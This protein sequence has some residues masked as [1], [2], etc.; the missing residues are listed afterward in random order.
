MCTLVSDST[1]TCA[2]SCHRDT[3]NASTMPG[4]ALDPLN[5]SPNSE[6]RRRTRVHIRV[7]VGRIR[8]D[9]VN[10]L[11]LRTLPKDTDVTP[12]FRVSMAT[13]TFELSAGICD[14]RFMCISMPGIINAAQYLP[15]CP[16]STMLHQL[17]R[18]HT[19]RP[20]TASIYAS[21]YFGVHSRHRCDQ[22]RLQQRQRLQR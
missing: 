22:P 5:S 15:K 21:K 9:N 17:Q 13:G 2:F 8:G 20:A 12:Q 7:P 10:T 11:S 1:P 3:T 18:L 16:N 14:T 4:D 19:Y 6:H